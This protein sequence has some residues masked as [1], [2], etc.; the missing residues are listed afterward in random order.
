LKIINR[1]PDVYLLSDVV[2]TPK[3]VNAKPEAAALAEVLKALRARPAVVYCNT[4]AL[5]VD[6]V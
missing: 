6:T 5:V 4:V 3:R 2:A 1:L